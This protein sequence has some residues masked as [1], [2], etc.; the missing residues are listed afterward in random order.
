M[1]ISGNP[2]AIA[3]LIERARRSEDLRELHRLLR[4]E[5]AP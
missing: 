1:I 2:R 5:M 3:S 4:E